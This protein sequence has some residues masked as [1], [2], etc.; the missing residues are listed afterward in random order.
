M[1]RHRPTFSKVIFCPQLRFKGVF[2]RCFLMV[3][4]AMSVFYALCSSMVA[5]E[6]LDNALR[7]MSKNRD[8][9][10]NVQMTWLDEQ[11][12]SNSKTVRRYEFWSREGEYFRMDSEVLESTNDQKATVGK[13]SRL[14]VRPDR[15][16][17]LFS[18]AG[19]SFAIVGLGSQEEGKEDLY[20]NFV[21]DSSI[22]GY[23]AYFTNVFK[24]Y[25]GSQPAYRLIT[26][27]NTSDMMKARMDADGD[28]TKHYVY[29][30]EIN[31][32]RG[33]CTAWNEEETI[34]GQ[35]SSECSIIKRYD[36]DAIPVHILVKSR[37][38]M[39]TFRQEINRTS[40]IDEP[41]PIG[42]FSLEG[43]GI[44]TSSSISKWVR[45]LIILG[46]GISLVGI[47]AAYKY[48]QS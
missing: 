32:D 10:S 21:F 18:A 47:Y 14:V 26:A 11:T 12:T 33:V 39:G 36:K 43:Y 22:R 23:Y 31:L 3:I 7:A 1:K 42:V 40:F 20:S 24:E 44:T 8:L 48:R 28:D 34:A 27:Q 38:S 29:E 13:K 9:F 4:V 16:V 2:V 25:D 6:V 45:R 19:R 46:V 37:D 5:N 30:Y 41:A 17:N 35:K 15:Y